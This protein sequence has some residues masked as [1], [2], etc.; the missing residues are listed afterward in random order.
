MRYHASR[1]ALA[2]AEAFAAWPRPRSVSVHR[3][4]GLNKQRTALSSLLA[5][6]EA[7][8]AA[9]M[10]AVWAAAETL[11]AEQEEILQYLAARKALAEDEAF[12]A[13]PRPRSVSL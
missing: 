2:E 10:K 1:K 3:L 13:W 6:E 4:A 5:S 9:G 7:E 11:D 8:H 12:A